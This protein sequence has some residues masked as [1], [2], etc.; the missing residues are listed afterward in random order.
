MNYALIVEFTFHGHECGKI[1]EP[2][3]SFRKARQMNR[4]L[5]A[6]YAYSRYA[7]MDGMEARYAIYRVYPNGIAV[8]RENGHWVWGV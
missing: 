3:Q 6:K 2:V 7:A 1:E 4:E 5:C 8:Q